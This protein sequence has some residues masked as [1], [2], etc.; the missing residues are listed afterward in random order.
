MSSHHIVREKQEPALLVLG[1]A[2]FTDELLGQLLEWSPTVMV[3]ADTAEQLNAMGIK[4]DVVIEGD[5]AEL[6][7]DIKTIPAKG[8]SLAVA[9][10]QYLIGNKYPAVNI[11][12]DEFAVG[13][14]LPY[15]SNINIVIYHKGQK[16]YPVHNGFSKWKPAGETINVLNNTGRLNVTGL[17]PINESEYTTTHDGFFTLQFDAPFLLISESIL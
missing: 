8:D 1:L 10:L 11:I 6:Q 9:A 3:T 13:D 12:T 16:I 14:Y 2:N 5:N 4:V 7:S 17:D 15:I